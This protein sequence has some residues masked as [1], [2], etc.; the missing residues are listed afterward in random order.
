MVVRLPKTNSK[1]APEN[2]Q[3]PKKET[4]VFQQPSI[5]R[6]E[7]VGFR[8]G[9]LQMSS[10]FILSKGQPR[11]SSLPWAQLPRPQNR[12]ASMSINTTEC[13]FLSAFMNM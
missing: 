8:E 13:R 11:P 7:D 12:L 5:F 9:N 1:V 4:I 2:R 6:C 10:M 3:T